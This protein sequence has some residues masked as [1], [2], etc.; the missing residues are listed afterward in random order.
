MSDNKCPLCGKPIGESD[1]F[2]EDCHD[3]IEH[4]YETDF[5]E[6]DSLT[7]SREQDV[8]TS[9]VVDIDDKT[10]EEVVDEPLPKVVVRKPVSKVLIFT[11]IGCVVLIA[12]GFWQVI[13]MKQEKE[14]EQ[15][16]IAFWQ[17]CIEEN[18]PMAYSK[19]LETYQDG[20][21]A[22]DAN[23][24]IREIREAEVAAWEKLKKSSDINAFYSYLSENP[25]TPYL[26]QIK[27]IMD[28]LSWLSVKKD[29]TE[30]A[31]KAYLENVEL[32]NLSGHHRDEAKERFTYLSEIVVL[33]GATLTNQK[34]EITNFFEKL[35]HHVPRELLKAFAPKVYFY[36]A[37]MS[38]TEV[39][40][41]IDK[42]YK[43]QNIKAITYSYK[44][45]SVFAK[46]DNKGVVF[47]E[48]VVTKEVTF[49]T[50]KKKKEEQSLNLY[51]EFNSNH[52]VQTIKEIKKK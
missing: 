6:E 3:H 11:L 44:P 41:V 26:S 8:V 51:L 46:K 39:V 2:C 28:S 21:F 7:D 29:E 45:E 4:Q 33:D 37:E 27:D 16:E 48:L 49:N 42:E 10:T 30:G 23:L 18:T 15:N 9:A 14:A 50:R 35:S 1:S 38:S 25:E 19:Y 40:A 34:L 12:I 31:Y 43:D 32:G 17:K 52:Q 20:Q 13:R 24:K 5:L 22:E 47:V 36:S